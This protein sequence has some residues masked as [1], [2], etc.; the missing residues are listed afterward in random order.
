MF[1]WTFSLRKLLDAGAGDGLGAG[2]MRTRV[3]HCEIVEWRGEVGG[4]KVEAAW[5]RALVASLVRLKIWSLF[6]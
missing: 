2:E 5:W 3:D 6:C 1:A 4:G